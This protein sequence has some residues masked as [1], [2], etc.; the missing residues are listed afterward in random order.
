MSVWRHIQLLQESSQAIEG[1]FFLG[2]GQ[3]DSLE[4]GSEVEM[5][6]LIEDLDES[7]VH[8]HVKDDSVYIG[9]GGVNGVSIFHRDVGSHQTGKQVMNEDIVVVEG[10]QLGYDWRGSID[11][12]SLEVKCNPDI[13]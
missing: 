7:L 6:D 11:R 9:E 13:G 4:D 2:E 5:R 1:T 12:G 10:H 8:Q 3:E